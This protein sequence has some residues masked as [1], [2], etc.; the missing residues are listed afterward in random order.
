MARPG[1]D[2]TAARRSARA[3]R[4]TADDVAV[5]DL[6]GVVA[7]FQPELRLHRLAQVTQLTEHDVSVGLFD[8]GLDHR[9]ELGAFGA[10]E[11]VDVLLDALDHRLTPTGLV[12]AWALAFEPDA[13][14]LEFMRTLPGR[15]FILT[16]NGPMLN[17]CLDGPLKVVASGVIDVICS[18]QL[19][20]RKPDRM[21]FRRAA[22]VIGA[23]PSRLALFDD[24][25]RNVESARECGWG[26]V[27][28][29]ESKRFGD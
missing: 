25:M 14:V 19:Q 9:A 6:G 26:A 10:D 4:L 16:N 3:V 21:A 24:D 20:C 15:V 18:W 17:H 7:R 2:A 28:V 1:A 11:I 27:L 22:R 29:D 5:F 23:E 13:L 8:S 12:N